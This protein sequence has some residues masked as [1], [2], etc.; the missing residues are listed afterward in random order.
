MFSDLPCF[1][2]LDVKILHIQV[3]RRRKPPQAATRGVG[4]TFEFIFLP[5][6]RVHPLGFPAPGLVGC[7]SSGSGEIPSS[8]LRVHGLCGVAEIPFLPAMATY[9]RGMEA[10]SSVRAQV[11][12]GSR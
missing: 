4:G 5:L 8:H 1:G 12:A 9:C 6:A 7:L 3:Y 2:K 11:R 10:S